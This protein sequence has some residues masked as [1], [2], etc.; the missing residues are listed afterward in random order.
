MSDKPDKKSRPSDDSLESSKRRK[1]AEQRISTKSSD[2]FPTELS[3]K[4]I[5]HIMYELQ[6][7][8]IE[9]EMQNEELNRAYQEL[10]LNQ[11]RYFDLYDL[12]PV[13]YITISEKGLILEANLTIADL[14][15][16]NRAALV[17]QLF[18]GFIQKEDQDIYYLHRKRLFED[19]ETQGCDLR[20]LGKDNTEI[21]V[22]ITATIA[23]DSNG[24]PVCRAI[25]HDI[26]KRKNAE[27]E[28]KALNLNLEER[29][30]TRTSQLENINHELGTFSYSVSHNLRSP[31]RA[32]NGYSEII[33]TDYSKNLDP[34]VLKHIMTIRKNSIMMG[35]LVDE[36]LN[37]SKL[38]GQEL[39]L[40]K[41][42]LKPLILEIISNFKEEI[43]RR[44]IKFKINTLPDCEADTILIQ[45]VFENL[46]SNAIKYT[47]KQSAPYIKIGSA[48]AIPPDLENQLQQEVPCYFVQDNG[49]GFDMKYYDKLF[50]VFQRLHHSEE[51]E[52][53]G[54]GLAFVSSIITKHGGQIWADA[55]ID[56]GATFYFTIGKNIN[57]L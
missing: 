3:P 17:K 31:L 38:G 4:E 10:A 36:L 51:F 12:A 5:Q 21:W 32:I 18:S 30:K 40:N 11:Q 2:L 33:L 20:M 15:G 6:V 57:K 28:I 50:G 52:G 1:L 48:R 23:H 13:G 56:E 43:D 8:Q 29:V 44:K 19:N 25:I 42:H 9:L 54:I 34:E 7:H 39:V 45:Q 37:F 41:V 47:R 35:V 53:F 49:I 27:S 24:T 16:V 22:H 14:V 46:I 26:T 55:K